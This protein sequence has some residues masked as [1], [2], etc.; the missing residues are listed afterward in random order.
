MIENGRESVTTRKAKTGKRLE[1]II[2]KKE[3][4]NR[5]ILY[6]KG[7]RIR[8]IYNVQMHRMFV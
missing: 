2:W 3:A 7:Y 1:R 6:G 4:V 5:D 8:L